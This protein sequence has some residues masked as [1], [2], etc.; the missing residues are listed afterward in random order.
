MPDTYTSLIYH[1]VFATQGREAWI[2]TDIEQRV[3]NYVGALVDRH[4]MTPLGV[5]GLEDHLHG[6]VGMPPTLAV[7]A[8]VKLIKG[9]SSRRIR[10]TFPDLEMFSW[11]RG[12][13]AFTVSRSRLSALLTYVEEQRAR[14]ERQTSQDKYRRL[15]VH[16]GVSDALQHPDSWLYKHVAERLNEC[17][18]G[19]HSPTPSLTLRL[20]P[21][22]AGLG[23]RPIAGERPATVHLVA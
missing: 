23:R 10:A 3:R 5:G 17:R 12:Y 15:L 19:I 1:I 6:V 7:S 21:L 11:Q 2:R 18:R 8:A 9:G 16:H 13:G 4:G 14:H 20:S 22:R